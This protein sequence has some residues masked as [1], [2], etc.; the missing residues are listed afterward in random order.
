MNAH[1]SAAWPLTTKEIPNLRGVV[2]E[3]RA[4]GDRIG[5][6]PTM[7]ALHEGH[8]TLVR[9]A[10]RQCDHVVVSIFV[11]PTQFGPNEDYSRYPRTVEA[12]LQLLAGHAD[13]VWLPEVEDIYPPYSATRVTVGAAADVLCGAHRPGHFD[14]VATVV[15]ILLNAVRPDMAFFGEKDYQQLFIIRRMAADLGLP[16]EIMGVPTVREADGL[17]LSSR[18]R[19]LGPE[20]RAK[21]PLLHMVMREIASKSADG[22]QLH[23]AL[24]EGRATLRN[25]GFVIDYLEARD[26]RTLAPLPEPS[27]HGRLFVA[28]RLG[29][30]RLID[31]LALW[32]VRV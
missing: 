18:N 24:E 17:A 19:Y 20:E 27:L 7:G 15:T 11:N 26:E 23:A 8:L 31:N 30:T 2:A 28:A 32:D 3:W 1:A 14:G 5:F 22:E 29:S 16:G 25:A 9:E 10:K 12:D 21:A 13:L 4:Q 6:V